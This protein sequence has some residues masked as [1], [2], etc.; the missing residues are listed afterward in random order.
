MGSTR[1]DERGSS[2]THGWVWPAGMG[3]VAGWASLAMG[4]AKPDQPSSFFVLPSLLS[5]SFSAGYDRIRC[6]FFYT[7]FLQF[8]CFK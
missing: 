4:A 8:F 6:F 5:L 3:G 2:Q 7:S 1:E